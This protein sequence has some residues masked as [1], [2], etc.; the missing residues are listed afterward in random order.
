MFAQVHLLSQSC[1]GQGPE[2]KDH[3]ISHCTGFGVGCSQ[4]YL[5]SQTV[6]QSKSSPP[7]KDWIEGVLGRGMADAFAE[8]WPDQEGRFTC[9]DQYRNKRSVHPSTCAK[10]HFHFFCPK[11]YI[12][13][14]RI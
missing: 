9:W 3:V 11:K 2:W 4:V 13:D 8:M 10:K 1:I 14:V 12:A 5:L 6:G 7:C